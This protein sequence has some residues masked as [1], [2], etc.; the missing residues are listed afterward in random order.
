MK[1][2]K[3]VNEA[4]IK[5]INFCDFNMDFEYNVINVITAI[6]AIK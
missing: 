4:A 2:Y 5:S 6:A 3:A 1:V